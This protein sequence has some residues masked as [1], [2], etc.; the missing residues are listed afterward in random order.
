MLELHS[1][2]PRFVALAIV[3]VLLTVASARADEAPVPPPAPMA[4]DSAEKSRAPHPEPRVI[5]N[6]LAVRGP[7]GRAGVERSA[8]GGWGRIIKCYKS[9]DRRARGM[10]GV[11][12][13]V[14]SNG[15]VTAVRRTRSSLK[16]GNLATCLANALLGLSMPKAGGRSTANAEIHV[17]PGDS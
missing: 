2:H 16:N 13:A 9:F 1:F 4:P 17:A 10:V 6:V 3:A 8:R 7:H 12:F 11:E 14:G 5:V 15:R